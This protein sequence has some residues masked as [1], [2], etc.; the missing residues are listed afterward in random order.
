[1]LPIHTQFVTGN[2][3]PKDD[4]SPHHA[5]CDA[6]TLLY[7]YVFLIMLMSGDVD[8]PTGLQ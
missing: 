1:V 4:T 2:E 5:M 7:I 8:A 3:M 6:A